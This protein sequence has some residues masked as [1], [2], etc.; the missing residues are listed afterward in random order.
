MHLRPDQSPIS[1]SASSGRGSFALP[2][3]S[4][5]SL[6]SEIF[7]YSPNSAWMQMPP[8]PELPGGTSSGTSRPYS[9]DH[10]DASS[11]PATSTMTLA[12]PEISQARLTYSP[13]QQY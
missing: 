8:T 13:T 7:T 4:P 10:S 9:Y 11:A 12:N 3:S 5:N 2:S 6:S 1:S